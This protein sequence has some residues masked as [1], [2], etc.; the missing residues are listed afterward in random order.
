MKTLWLLVAVVCTT[1]TTSCGNH[2][3]S[4]DWLTSDDVHIAVDETFR[5]IMEEEMEVF[6][7]EHPEASMKPVFC[8]ENEALRLLLCDSLRSC[9]VTRPLTDAEIKTIRSHTLE[10]RQSLIATDAFALIVN[11]ENNDTL[12][13]LDEIKKIVTGQITKWE[14][15]KY[16]KKR[17]TLNLVF[18]HEGSSTVRYMTDSLCGGKKLSGNLY[19]QGSNDSVIA[20]VKRNPDII[21]VVGA[22]WLKSRKDSALYSFKNLDVNVMWVSRYADDARRE[23]FRPYQY[24]IATAE[25][26]LLRSVYAI[27]TDPRSQSLERVFYFFLKGQKGQLI[28]CNYSQMLPITPVQI[29][30]VSIND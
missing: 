14:E 2:R 24:N 1:L 30:A 5:P 8:S 7:L 3:K 21:G 22:N 23:F 6:A 25:Y 26:P 11:K 20:L 28:I 15:L 17:G 4:A 19:A 13:T 16:A 18:D 12:I 9:I 10:P 29:K 27:C